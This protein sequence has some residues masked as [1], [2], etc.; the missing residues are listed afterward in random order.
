MNSRAAVVSPGEQIEL[1]IDSINHNGEGVGRYK[2]VAVFVPFT[3]PGEKVVVEVVELK[4][5]YILAKLVNHVEESG[6][7]VKPRCPAFDTCGGSQFQ[8]IDYQLQLSLK[9]QLVEDALRRIGKI[10]D[11]AVE[12]TLGMETP[13]A[14]RNKAQF[15]VS[16][17]NGK[18]KFG[19]FEEG[20]HALVPTTECL[21]ID[22]QISD[23]AALVEGI[24]NKYYVPAYNWETGRGLLR[25]VVIRKGWATGKIMVVLVTSGKKFGE[26]FTLAREIKAR[27]P[28][29]AS[30]VRNINNSPNRTV[31]GRDN[32]V[33]AGQMTITDQI[34]GLT[35]TISPTSFYQV[36]SKQTEVLYAKALEFAGLSG[37]ET[38]LDVYCG[39][40]AISLFL[41][42]K[43]ARVFGFELSAESV[44][45]AAENARANK[46]HNVEFVSGKAEERLPKL[47]RTGIKP[48]VVVV[49]PPRQG[50]EK[51]ALQAIADMAPER[52]VY[53]SC[54]PATMAR[55]LNFLSYR[56]Y[57]AKR[58]QPV[59]MFPQT[60]H[61]ETI[62]MMTNC[63]KDKK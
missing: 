7:R 10:T 35:F 19:F 4:K 60:A 50:I 34:D 58:V 22:Q 8:H 27:V 3:I 59:D 48:D 47:V 9:R 45:D 61:V 24:I 14:Y 41:A 33:L 32:Q 56:G 30:V 52:I 2:G 29:I 13:W 17:V 36:N 55:D 43:A 51:R 15:Q 18:V 62:I 31:F 44:R 20:S 21:L 26:L 37:R 57:Q 16:L 42:R 6:H 38:V 1:A 40:G 11:V 46:I 54:D 49:D 25:H 39:I 23:I 53:I 28:Q 12:E 5:N 63:G